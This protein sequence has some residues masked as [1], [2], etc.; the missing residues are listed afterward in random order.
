MLTI[1]FNLCF[2]IINCCVW[3]WGH[4]FKAYKPRTIWKP[5]LQIVFY[6]H[7]TFCFQFVF[8]VLLFHI[9]LSFLAFAFQETK[10]SSHETLQQVV[11]LCPAQILMCTSHFFQDFVCSSNSIYFSPNSLLFSTL[12]PSSIRVLIFTWFGICSSQIEVA[13]LCLEWEFN[14]KLI[15]MHLNIVQENLV[16]YRLK[17]QIW[18]Y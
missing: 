2:S 8:R 7:F 12:F 18:K 14:L 4:N 13:D 9:F 1:F 6:F 11:L 15:H 10:V 16:R 17:L 5:K 3:F